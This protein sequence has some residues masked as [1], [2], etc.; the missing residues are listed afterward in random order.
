M[1]LRRC[2]LSRG[3]SLVVAHGVN[4]PVTCGVF[5]D[6]EFNCVPCIARWITN[7]HWATR[8][9]SELFHYL[10]TSVV[11]D[12]RCYIIVLLIFISLGMILNILSL[13][14]CHL[15]CRNVY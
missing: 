13:A 4:C 9:A 15:T 12:I 11:G 5:L 6:Q 10:I 3:H 8:L 14:I 1:L 7:P 2:F